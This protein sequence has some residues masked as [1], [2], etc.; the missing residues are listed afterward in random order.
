VRTILISLVCLAATSSRLGAQTAAADPAA[1]GRPVIDFDPDWTPRPVAGDVPW[2]MK[3]TD[4]E[5]LDPRLR[6]MD[7]G[8]TWNAT[9]RYALSG[10]TPLPDEQ[11]PVTTHRVFKGTAIRVGSHGEA[12]LLF[13]R[14][15]CR[16]ACG[17]TGPFL[18][19]KDRRFG[20]LNTPQP[21]GPVRMATAPGA[22]WSLGD[23]DWPETPP[24]TGP[25]PEHWLKFRALFRHGERT[26]VTYTV[27]GQTDVAEAPWFAV[28]HGSGVFLRSMRIGPMSQA[29]RVRLWTHAES[30]E[31]TVTDFVG[32]PQGCI[33]EVHRQAGRSG[34]LAVAVHVPAHEEP[35][36]ITLA[37]RVDAA[38]VLPGSEGDR[39]N[40]SG[41]VGALPPGTLQPATHADFDRWMSPGPP[42][43][44]ERIVTGGAVASDE[45]P[46]VV[47][48][49]ELPFENPYRALMFLSGVDFVPRD[50]VGPGGPGVA[51]ATDVVVSTAHGDVW[52]LRGV[53]EDLDE[54]VWKRFATGL[55]Q[56]LGLKVVDG[57]VYVLERGQLT[58]LQDQ[59]GDGEADVYESFHADWHVAGGEHSFDTC[60][61]RD[62]AGYWYFHSTGDPQVPTGGTLIRVTPDGL[63][64]E[65][66]CTGFRHPIGL[67]VLPDGRITGA[68]QEGNWM[69]STRVD[70]YRRGGFY[71]DMRAH[72]RETPPQTYDSPLC[73][74]PRQLD[75]SAG[76]EV[77]V[78]AGAWG[79]LGGQMLHLSYGRCRLLLLLMQRVGEMEQGG[80]VDLGL[81][82]ESGIQRGRFRPDDGHLYVVGMD[83][84]QTAAVQDGCLQRIR[85]TGREFR[86]PL[87]L[88]VEPEGIR[89]TFSE[90]LDR[91]VAADVGRYHVEQWNY[92]WRAEYGSPRYS[93]KEP[94]AEGQDEVP[95]ESVAVDETGREVLLVIRGLQ[96]VMQMQLD[97][98]LRDVHGRPVEG[99]LYNTIHTTGE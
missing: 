77:A 63:N 76:G 3:E 7:T 91:E 27:G 84:W 31:R 42:Q 11:T 9:F 90:P 5:W 26:V 30:A 48:T 23:G 51:G 75:N 8:R 94:E 73:W 1:A 46:L 29:R 95:V 50:A 18:W 69:P 59:N 41:H 60:L 28:V 33:L 35:I 71:G 2:Y 74:L 57:Q 19:H 82:F 54:V 44:T 88:R 56:P 64:S 12:G 38:D 81:Q 21:A 43:W 16:W 17:W 15:E 80:A 79:P 87:G 39:P 52:L 96:P 32:D 78:P 14:N 40:Q 24:A 83:G 85:W 6:E 25:L 70:I 47:D 22:G 86:T 92:R 68:D 89:I 72:H 55:Y 45:G 4:V 93:V 36:V 61:E 34:A 99:V 20:L 65:V 67:G 49:V 10:P 13:D 37:T 53:D 98:R 97:Y 66:F 58:R 62:P